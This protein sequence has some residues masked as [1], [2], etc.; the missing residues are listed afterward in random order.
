MANVTFKDY[1][2]IIMRKLAGS[3]GGA[4]KDV[5]EVAVEAIQSKMLYGYGDY[6]GNPPHTEIVDTGALFDSVSAEVAQV[7]QN[8]F[9]VQAGAGTHY[10]KYVHEGTSKLKGRPFITD[11]LTEASS[12]IES[13][14]AKAL[15]QGMK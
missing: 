9:T 13:A 2:D 3:L 15:R 11:G 10:A 14:I 8:A 6:H 4:A 1:S 5:A 7:S 12:E